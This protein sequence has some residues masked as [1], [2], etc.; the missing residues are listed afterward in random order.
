MNCSLPFVA[1]EAY[2]T[3]FSITGIHHNA[4][5][6][7]ITFEMYTKCCYI[8]CIDLTPDKETDKDHFILSAREM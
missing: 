4:R 5:A 3:L 7:M 2:E 6:Q 8:L 1:T